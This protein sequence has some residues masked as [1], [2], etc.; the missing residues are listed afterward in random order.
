MANPAHLS[1]W[2]L[3]ASSRNRRNIVI[4]PGDVAV[5]KSIDRES[6]ENT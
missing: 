2:L 3:M 1:R 5:S 6:V 4:L